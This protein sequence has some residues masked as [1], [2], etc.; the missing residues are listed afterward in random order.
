M[1]KELIIYDLDGTIVDTRRDI[2]C[3]V[4]HMLTQMGFPEMSVEDVCRHVGRGLHHLIQGTL[5]IADEKLV[6]KGCKIYRDYYV[7][8]LLDHTQLYPGAKDFLEYFK[9]RKQAVITNKPDP[10]SVEILKALGV[11]DYFVEVI[12]GNSSYPA[13]PAPDGVRAIMEREK[14]PAEKT[15]FVG[16][17]AIDFETAQN[18]GIEIVLLSHGFSTEAE[19]RE[20]KPEVLCRNFEELTRVVQAKGY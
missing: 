4:N 14:I 16:D 6:E 20:L 13:K 15:I 10:Y 2:A 12:A 5:Q 1:K 3:A 9:D 19:L 8:H 17:S 18:A 7:S 11:L